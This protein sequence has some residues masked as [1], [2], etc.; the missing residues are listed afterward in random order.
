M[1]STPRIITQT[2]AVRNPSLEEKPIVLFIV[3]P[4]A[5]ASRRCQTQAT[6]KAAS[7]QALLAFRSLDP[8]RALRE[9]D[10]RR[11]DEERLPAPN[12]EPAINQKRT[13]DR[14]SPIQ[15]RIHSPPAESRAN[16]T[17]IPVGT[18]RSQAVREARPEQ[19]DRS[20]YR[21]RKRKQGLQ[22]AN[23]PRRADSIRSSGHCQSHQSGRIGLAF[24]AAHP[25]DQPVSVNLP[26][27]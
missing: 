9:P 13:L 11:R 22:S 10:R 23:A 4:R 6:L 17:A 21:R 5:Q 3:P 19:A 15:V 26:G 1:A 27:K 20:D 12:K 18:A 25:R 2:G 7:R 24:N 16:F 8:F 14:K